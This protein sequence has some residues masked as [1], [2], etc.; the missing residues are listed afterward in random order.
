M[1]GKELVDAVL[2]DWRTAPIAEPVRAMLGFLE[3]LA[4]APDTLGAGDV[5]RLRAAGISRQAIEEAVYVCVIFSIIVRVADA[6]DF[7]IPSAEGF[8]VS[9]AHLLERGYL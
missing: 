1:L 7:A 8:D 9:A 2:A 3:R 4:G 5:R 6:L